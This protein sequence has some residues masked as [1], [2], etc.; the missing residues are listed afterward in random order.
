MSRRSTPNAAPDV[1]L[2]DGDI[3]Y[4]CELFASL[5]PL[6]TH[7]MFGGLALYSDGVIFA[8]MLS[9]GRVMLKGAGAMQDRF[10]DMGL[11]RWT[12]NRDGK[13]PSAMPYW[14]LP[15]SALDDPDAA[16]GL[17]RAALAHL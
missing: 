6:T 11:I 13:P 1:A 17:A 10:D 7:K 12:S 5:G 3:A 8:V 14:A 2:T 4:V 15:E 16:A 9:D